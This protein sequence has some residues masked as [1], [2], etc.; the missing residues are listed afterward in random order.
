MMDNS[1]KSE[2][3]KGMI[4]KNVFTVFITA[5]IALA[6][7]SAAA[8]TVPANNRVKFNIDIGWKLNVGDVTGAQAATFNDASWKT[9]SLPYSWNQDDAFAVKSGSVSQ[10]IAWYRKH[11]S[12]PVTYAGCKVF[13]EFEEIRQAGEVYCNGTLVGR[14]ENGVSPSGFDITSLVHIDGTDNVIAVKTDNSYDYTEVSSGT[15]FQWSTGSYTTNFGGITQNAYL[16]VTPKCYQTLPLIVGLNTVGTYIYGKNYIVSG[17]A[18]AAI[19]TGSADITAS[20]QVKNESGAS[21]TVGFQVDIVDKD[22]NLVKTLNGA[23]ATIA[24]GAAA[25]VTVTGNVPGLNLWSLGY[26]YLYDVYTI[27]SV[28]GT[29]TDVVKTRTGFR[30]MEYGGGI[31]KIND[32]MYEVKGFAWRSQD[33]W[34]ALGDGVPIWLRIFQDSLMLALG[35]NTVRPMHVA[36]LRT[37]IEAADIMGLTYAMPAG[38]AE[39][40]VTGAQW[41]QRKE[42]MRDQ[43]VYS[44][45]NPSV[46]W[47]EAGNS[48][49]SDNQMQ[50]MID[51]MTK[52]DPSGGRLT[53]C[54]GM[55]SSKVAQYG[56]EML[57]VDKSAYKPMWMN[58]YSRNE[59]PRRWWDQYSPPEFHANDAGASTVAGMNMNQDAYIQEECNRWW[60]YYTER[61]GS[62]T[63]PGTRANLGGA[64]IEMCDGT[65]FARSDE[66]Y[67]RSGVVDAMRIPKDAY[68]AFKCFWDGWIEVDNKDVYIV[69]HWTYPSDTKKNTEY[70]VSNCD[71]VELFV[72]N[73]SKGFGKQS[74]KFLFT[75]PNAPYAP[76]TVK[77]VGYKA[78]GTQVAVDQRTTAGAAAA[79]RLTSHISAAGLRATGADIALF[80][81]EVTDAN[82]NRCPTASNTITWAVTGP[83]EYRG[84]MAGNHTGAPANY[85]LAT[86]FPVECGISR[87]S[88]RASS[89]PGDIKVTASSSGLTGASATVTSSAFPITNGLTTVMPNDGLPLNLT[90]L[91]PYKLLNPAPK[92][93]AVTSSAGNA[94]YDDNEKT[95]WSGSSIT[96]NLASAQMV[97]QVH[98]KFTDF[99]NAHTWKVAVG[100]T[101]AWSGTTDGGLGYSDVSFTP[102]SG[103]SVTISS[104]GSLPIYETEIYG[105]GVVGVQPAQPP[106]V[107][108]GSFIR[109]YQDRVN[110][111]LP[112]PGYKV[113]LMDLFG[114]IVEQNQHQ[115][116]DLS[117]GMVSISTRSLARGVYL[118]EVLKDKQS[119]QKEVLFIQ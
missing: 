3:A 25:T 73:V 44:K 53:G 42:A 49:I 95:S 113:N 2:G 108:G 9:I 77:A 23:G 94:T 117:A 88:V 63:G 51:T 62:G 93:L 67:R 64:K 14:S 61:P 41:N 87:I 15:R 110:I 71:K 22:G 119:V 50:E 26:G 68:G 59:S 37:E 33:P 60:E 90:P 4:N 35:G 103:S 20:S 52:Y 1:I 45:N 10:G 12:L 65:T 6:S 5:F 82:G 106:S 47:Y 13:V 39:N 98:V 107:S 76:G 18:S 56:G 97:S 69:G 40:A 114:R 32:R 57:Y 89:T 83:G 19:P 46:L 58:E 91:P 75:F 17:G 96:Y 104:S 66:N 30:K 112:G 27:L 55:V 34:P 84:G 102:V 101:Q 38:D 116:K 36:A 7:V 8:Y 100:G 16:H 85:I 43:M 111:T 92:T 70:V 11:F 80:D 54:R 118:I 79:I 115:K 28:G 48:D 24:A 21:Q 99:R 105:P 29:A 31:A 81:A 72:N 78:D 74:W 109:K 86:S